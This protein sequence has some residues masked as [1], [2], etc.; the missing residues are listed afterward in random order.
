[1]QRY[2][3]GFK[4]KPVRC[5]WW[6]DIKKAEGDEVNRETERVTEIYRRYLESKYDKINSCL[7]DSCAKWMSAENSPEEL[8][9]GQR[10]A[11][12]SR[13]TIAEY[14]GKLVGLD[15]QTILRCGITLNILDFP[16]EETSASRY[17][18]DAVCL[19][20]S[21]GRIRPYMDNRLRVMLDVLVKAEILYILE[22]KK[23]T[24]AV[25]K[26]Q[27]CYCVRIE[28][29]R[30]SGELLL[31]SIRMLVGEEMPAT[32]W[33]LDQRL[34]PI[35]KR[36]ESEAFAEYIYKALKKKQYFGEKPNTLNI[37]DKMQPSPYTHRITRE[38]DVAATVFFYEGTAACYDG[39]TKTEKP[40]R[41]GTIWVDDEVIEKYTSRWRRG[42]KNR[43]AI[44][45]KKVCFHEVFH[46]YSSWAH[47]CLAQLMARKNGQPCLSYSLSYD[48]KNRDEGSGKSLIAYLE[49]LDEMCSPRL[50]MPR[51]LFCRKVEERK[52]KQLDAGTERICWGQII[53]E[54]AD[55]FTT[56]R[57]STKL[58]LIELGYTDAR[59]ARNWISTLNGGFYCRE[60]LPPACLDASHSYEIS[61]ADALREHRENPAFRR[62]LQKYSFAYV[63]G[64]YVL[65][66]PRYVVVQYGRA[67]LT[68]YALSHMDECCILFEVAKTRR[69]YAG[70]HGRLM[71]QR[72]RAN[73]QVA[74]SREDAEKAFA[75]QSLCLEMNRELDAFYTKHE[76]SSLHEVLDDHLNQS[77]L[78]EFQVAIRSGITNHTLTNYRK[79][80]SLPDG[81][82]LL[83]IIIALELKGGY[84]RH[85]FSFLGMDLEDRYRYP[86]STVISAI[87]DANEYRVTVEQWDV[88][89]EEYYSEYYK[90]GFIL[91]TERRKEVIAN[92]KKTGR[93]S[94]C[95]QRMAA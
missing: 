87:L 44:L 21:V 5:A 93:L 52:T 81:F 22:D 70:K 58:R 29:K 42:A 61:R 36:E 43:A 12:R 64:H 37:L 89:I 50:E 9:V 91:D 32:G 18:G 7:Q 10:E 88:L 33:P 23:G 49:K 6:R 39:G 46:W 35:V 2:Y 59:G 69:I 79:G 28:F 92:L 16:K 82:T 57:E 73:R 86:E 76:H 55:E 90:N 45:K 95:I 4:P 20:Y 94:R 41:P 54:L 63:D 38:Y 80:L 31:K 24:P 77:S 53:D 15:L 51:S 1:M 84:R 83:K 71:R 30:P 34:V 60:Y 11:R 62:L 72:E 25:Q 68:E 66:D 8:Y 17:Y 65:D 48:L 3:L 26:G 67:R 40:V 78:S 85:L 47:F 14:L 75:N 13:S 56:T 19:E 27:G 74:Y